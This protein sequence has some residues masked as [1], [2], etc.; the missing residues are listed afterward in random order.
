[1]PHGAAQLTAAAPHPQPRSRPQ[2]SCH[3]AAEQ[4]S[5]S[6]QDKKDPW[7][8]HVKTYCSW[9]QLYGHLRR[10]G[11]LET[12]D[13]VVCT[14]IHIYVYTH[15]HIRSGRKRAVIT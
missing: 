11:S 13:N 10:G 6:E 5:R 8:G 9:S 15:T 14:H 2:C 4:V 3:Q 12:D 7:G 1:M